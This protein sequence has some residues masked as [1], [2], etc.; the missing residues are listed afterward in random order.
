VLILNKKPM[1]QDAML[2]RVQNLKEENRR[3]SS[4]NDR[5]KRQIEKLTKQQSHEA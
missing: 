3:L 5:L 2:I 4:E 1:K